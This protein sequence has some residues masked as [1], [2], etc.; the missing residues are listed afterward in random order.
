MRDGAVLLCCCCCSAAGAAYLR[1]FHSSRCAYSRDADRIDERHQAG[2]A[3]HRRVEGR[4][5]AV[6]NERRR[7]RDIEARM[8]DSMR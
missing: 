3:H 7:S 2:I 1:C 5:A 8:S 4:L 6:L